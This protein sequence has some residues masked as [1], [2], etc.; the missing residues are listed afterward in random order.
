MTSVMAYRVFSVRD[1]V[2]WSTDRYTH[3]RRRPYISTSSK[4]DS[5]NRSMYRKNIFSLLASLWAFDGRWE[6]D[7]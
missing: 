3:G 1:E 6:K 4:R 2:F 7:E 5:T